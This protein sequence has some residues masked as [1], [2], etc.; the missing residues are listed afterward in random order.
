M[1]QIITFDMDTKSNL[2][3]RK[4]VKLTIQSTSS[5]PVFFPVLGHEKFE[6]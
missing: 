5:L 2:T 4:K 3:V 1:N 6:I